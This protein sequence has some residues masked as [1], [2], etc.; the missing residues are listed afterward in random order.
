MRR[1][2]TPAHADVYD[3]KLSERYIR[4]WH[5]MH[6]M[7]RSA[8]RVRIKLTKP[9]QQAAAAAVVSVCGVHICLLSGLLAGCVAQT[10]AQ[11]K[12]NSPTPHPPRPTPQNRPSSAG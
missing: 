10:A 1:A 12:L 7:A 8:D 6:Q 4:W 2:W 9:Q 11:Q 3:R 5:R